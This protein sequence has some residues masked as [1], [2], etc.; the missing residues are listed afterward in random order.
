MSFTIGLATKSDDAA[1][2]ALLARNPVPGRITVTYEREPDYFAGCAAMGDLCQVIAAREDET[3][4]LAAVA[5]RAVRRLYVDGEPATVGYLGQLRVDERF[6]GRWLLSRGFAFLRDLHGDGRARSYLAT[7]IDGSVEARALLVDRPR[8]HYPRF[9]EMG[10]LNTLAIHARG[11]APRRHGGWTV[12]RAG[13]DDSI[14]EIVAA[15]GECGARRALFPV[16]DAS[17]LDGDGGL[18]GL[19]ANDLF[20]ARRDGRIAGAIAVWNQSAFKQTVVRGYSGALDYLRPLYNASAVAM[21]RPRLPRVGDAIGSAFAS[22]WCVASDDAALFASL[23]SAARAE[24]ARRG[25]GYLML[26]VADGDPLLAAARRFP[27]VLYRSTIYLVTWN[28][29]EELHGRLDRRPLYL[30]IATL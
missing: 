13:E 14:D 3:G 29:E 17:D 12:E 7:V 15:I 21:G 11:G 1:I 26:G 9:R 18:P 20:V 22:L 24:T 19:T 28:D 16:V 27:H 23:V 2:R 8:A 10:R 5:C 30:E 25:L 6:R 4:E